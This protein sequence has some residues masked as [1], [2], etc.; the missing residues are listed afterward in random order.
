MCGLVSDLVI[1]KLKEYD[2]MYSTILNSH[3][4]S[5]RTLTVHNGGSKLF[6]AMDTLIDQDGNTGIAPN[7]LTVTRHL[8]M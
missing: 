4:V 8:R 2:V 3:V 7:V 6:A 5:L 1:Y